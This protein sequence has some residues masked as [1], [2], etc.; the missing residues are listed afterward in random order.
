MGAFGWAIAI[1]MAI[2]LIPLIPF[3][4]VLKLVDILFGSN[5]QAR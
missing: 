5:E 1:G 4:L 2:V 3:V